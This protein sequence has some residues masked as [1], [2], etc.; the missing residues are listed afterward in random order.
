M[1]PLAYYMYNIN[2]TPLHNIRRAG[3]RMTCRRF[4]FVPATAESVPADM[5][6]EQTTAGQICIMSG[7]LIMTTA[8]AGIK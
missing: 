1:V 3:T 5:Y 4:N 8:L 7:Q 2:C 6:S